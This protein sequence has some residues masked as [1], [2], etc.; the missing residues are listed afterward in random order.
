MWP[1]KPKCTS[2]EFAIVLIDSIV[3]EANDCFLE[4]KNHVEESS[5]LDKEEIDILGEEIIRAYIWMFSYTFPSQKL[6]LD[7]LIELY[8]DIYIETHGYNENDDNEFSINFRLL[9]RINLL[10]RFDEYNKAMEIAN[11][12]R[13]ENQLLIGYEI[14]QFCFPKRKPFMDAFLN[15]ELMI[16]LKSFVDISFTV[17][18][19]CKIVDP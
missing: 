19:K 7:Y 11:Q 1:F 15:V 17:Y 3:K 13:N 14:L 16:N 12:S 6:I 9:E 2:K 10:V 18:N 5:N 4:L 8:L